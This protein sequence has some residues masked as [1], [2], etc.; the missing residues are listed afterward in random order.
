MSECVCV[1]VCSPTLLATSGHSCRCGSGLVAAESSVWLAGKPQRNVPS[2]AGRRRGWGGPSYSAQ[3][4]P[5]HPHPQWVPEAVFGHE[6]RSR[7]LAF[8]RPGPCLGDTHSVWVP[9]ERSRPVDCTGCG[10]L[11][12]Q[13][14][15]PSQLPLH[16]Q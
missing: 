13:P 1:C 5:S 4:L 8:S 7:A 11:L 9:P 16:S 6:G 12:A 2:S 14:F 15:A 3:A 10:S